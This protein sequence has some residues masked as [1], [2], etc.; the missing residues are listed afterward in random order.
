VS[1]RAGDGVRS[2][3]LSVNEGR[4]SHEASRKQ[5]GSGERSPRRILIL[6]KRAST[7]ASL[8]LFTPELPRTSFTSPTSTSAPRSFNSVN[9]VNQLH[10]SP[11]AL[12]NPFVNFRSNFW[13]L[14]QICLSAQLSGSLSSTLH[15]SS[16]PFSF[17]SFKRSICR[18]NC[19]TSN[20]IPCCSRFPLP[21]SDHCSPQ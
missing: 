20:T 6:V 18:P 17:N 9:S 3:L 7:S 2:D 1:G 5:V 15:R 8:C 14:L 10:P 19:T 12:S 13:S 16:I 21:R 4:R 11:P